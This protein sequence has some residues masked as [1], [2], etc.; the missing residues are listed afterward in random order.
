[1]NISNAL[2]GPDQSLMLLLLAALAGLAVFVLFYGVVMPQRGKPKRLG[3][4]RPEKQLAGIQTRLDKAQIEISAEEYLKRSLT[5]GI[6]MGIGLFLLIG[7]ILLVPVGVFAGFLFTWS[8]LEQ[9]RDRK[10]VRYS[11]QL[12]SVCDTI[13]TAYG[14]NPSLKKSIEAAAEY[15]ASPIK[16]DFQQILIASS[17]ERFVEGLQAVADFRRSIVFD[18]VATALIRASEATGEVGDMLQRLAESTRQNTAAFEDAMTSQIN[19]RSN[20][21]WGCFGPWMIFTAFKVMTTIMTLS[22]GV[23]VFNGMST[24]F[25]T[26]V[27]N[28][29]ALTASMVTMSVYLQANRTAQRGLVVKRISNSDSQQ[30]LRV[31]QQPLSTQQSILHGQSQPAVI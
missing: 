10:L 9:E 23:N 31:G 15:S 29:I 8:R 24:F 26:L 2:L 28:L 30:A 21:N 27:G 5:L 25:G 19:A 11:K 14:V 4:M 12:A 22:Q 20:I 1:M 13:R 3:N 6:P 17:Q 16:E 7:S 18:T